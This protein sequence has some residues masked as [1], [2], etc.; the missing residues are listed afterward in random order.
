[1]QKSSQLVLPGSSVHFISFNFIRLFSHLSV[2]GMADLRMPNLSTIVKLF[3]SFLGVRQLCSSCSR[4]RNSPALIPFSFL[5]FRFHFISLQ[6]RCL[7]G[8]LPPQLLLSLSSLLDSLRSAHIFTS[9]FPFV[10]VVCFLLSPLLSLFWLC[11]DLSCALLC[12]SEF[13]ASALSASVYMAAT[14]RLL[15]SFGFE[16]NSMQCL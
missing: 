14:H 2:S 4:I 13:C 3:L 7:Y 8:S 16:S 11:F 5:V 10:V 15:R 12:C 1:M 6:R 9:A